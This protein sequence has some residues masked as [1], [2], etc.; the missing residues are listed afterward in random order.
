M[1]NEATLEKLND[2][3]LKLLRLGE[4]SEANAVAYVRATNVLAD[5]CI[6]A[7][8]PHDEPDHEAWAA[9]RVARWLCA[10]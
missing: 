10:A 1:A 6:A 5:A 9:E 7:G 2:A 3:L 8:M 4:F